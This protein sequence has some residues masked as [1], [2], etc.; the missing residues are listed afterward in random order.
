MRRAIHLAATL[1]LLVLAGCSAS[2][3]VRLPT[4]TP[5]YTEHLHDPRYAAAAQAAGEELR[6]LWAQLGTPALSAAVSI[7]G[8]VV[9]A[10]AIG[11]SDLENRISATPGTRF[12]IGSTSKAVTATGLARLVDAGLMDLDKPI[13]R[14]LPDLPRQDW[15]PLTARQLASHTAGIVGYAENRDL[16]GL[17]YS[18]RESRQFDHVR[19]SLTLFDGSGLLF[20]PGTGFH[21]STFDTVLL[22]AVMEAAAGSDF[23]D[24]LRTLVFDPLGA[25]GAS[26]D[27]QGIEVPD[28]AVFYAKQGEGFRRWRAVNHSYKLAGGGMIATSTD[29]VRIGA[30]WFDADFIRPATVAD[31]WTPVRLTDGSINPQSYAIGWR[32]NSQTLLFGPDR[33]IHNVHHGGVSKGAFSWLNLYPDLRL[34]VALNANTRTGDFAE[35][36]RAEL[37]LTRLFAAELEKIAVHTR[38][39]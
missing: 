34:A 27:H 9:W 14:Y 5:P 17:Y 19:D 15:A 38:G 3:A 35:F 21:Y 30:G 13:Q 33:P 4:E 7:D 31:F 8:A 2:P 28:R 29:L 11:W 39:R 26:P 12:R 1:L 6:R 16:V 25:V 20:E 10:A 32:S 18:L 37:P 24:L 23:P 22:S 36:L